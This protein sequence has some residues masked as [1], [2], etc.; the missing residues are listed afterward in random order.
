M[1]ASEIASLLGG[2]LVGSDVEVTHI[3]EP[4][5]ATE[6]DVAFVFKPEKT[7][8]SGI[9][10]GL[11]I[12]PEG[13]SLNIP[14]PV[15]HVKDI[16]RAFIKLLKKFYPEPAKL[17]DSISTL[18][19]IGDVVMGNKVGVGEFT[20]IKDGTKIGDNTRIFS[21][22]YV[23]YNVLIGEN[24]IIYPGVKIYDN[25]KIGN[26]CIIHSNCVIG[27]DGFGY[28]EI[29][30]KREKIPQVGK[31][32]IGDH[33]EIGAGTTIDRSTLGETIIG[34]GVKI[35]NLVQIGH[36]VVIGAGSVIVAQTGIAGSVKIGKNVI[37]AGQVGVA[38]HLTI[39]DGAIVLAK[40]GVSK[41]VPPGKVFSGTP[42]RERK[43]YLKEIALVSR[44]PEIIEK[45]EKS[46]SK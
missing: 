10:A 38:D 17:P 6:N 3:K 36:N 35:D 27:S 8:V 44:L 39:G 22:V 34:N 32:I 46:L 13:V 20:V 18:A 23:G 26:N 4:E 43:K 7:D 28:F 31:V 2:R 33:V 9:K 42:A 19:S 21:H 29:D 24:C 45:V 41:S 12:L 15:I 40:S 30:G 14:T 5:K 11:L 1:K 37:L 16:E 25:V